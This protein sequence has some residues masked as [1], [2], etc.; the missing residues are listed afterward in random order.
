[1]KQCM[2][3]IRNFFRNASKKKLI[4]IFG[5][6]LSS[7]LIIAGATYA[8]VSFTITGTKDNLIKAGC[9]K[10]DL[11]EANNINLTNAV[12]VLDEQS[13]NLEPYKYTITNTCTTD[14]YYEANLTVLNTSNIENVSKMK[15]SLRGDSYL[16]PTIISALG[17]GNLPETQ[18]DVSLVYLLDSGYLKVGETKTFELRMWI[19]SETTDITGALDARIVM[20]A[21][22]KEGPRYKSNTSGYTV[23]KNTALASETGLN[24]SYSY[25]APYVDANNKYTQTSGLFKLKDKNNNLEYYFRGKVENNYLTFAGKTW[26]IIK[27]N[28]DGSLKLILDDVLST[29]AYSSASTTDSLNYSSSLISTSLQSW[30]NDNLK[31]NENYIVNYNYCNDLS[32]ANNYYGAYTRNVTSNSPSYFC[33]SDLINLNIGL[34]TADEIAYAGGLYN[35]NNTEYY[36]YKNSSWW[37]MS[38]A[39]YNSGAYMFNVDANG[40]LKTTLTTASN[41]YIRPVINLT[42]DAML[43]GNGT[44]NSKYNVI[45]F[46]TDDEVYVDTIPPVISFARSNASN[47]ILVGATDGARGSGI[48][49]YYISADSTTPTNSSEGWMNIK[50]E[51]FV[52]DNAYDPGTYYVWVK[53]ISGNISDYKKVI[54]SEKMNNPDLAS[55]MIPVY[56][57]ETSKVWRK[58]DSSNISEK[59]KWFDYS[60]KMWANAVTVRDFGFEDLSNNDTGATII[61]A[62]LSSEGLSFDGVDGAIRVDDGFGVTLPATYSATFKVDDFGSSYVVFIDNDTKIALYV[63]TEGNF[64]ATVGSSYSRF[65]AGLSANKFYN[66]TVV[67]NSLSDITVYVDGVS[68]SKSTT[69]SS[70]STTDERSY[71]GRRNYDTDSVLDGIIKN[72]MVW[73]EVLSQEQIESLANNNEYQNVPKNNLTTYFDFTKPITRAE[74]VNFGAGDIIPMNLINTMWVWIPRFNA[75]DNGTYNGGTQ[76][77][78]GAFNIEFVKN[79]EPAH[80]AFT[81][82]GK[83][84]NGFWFAKFEAG[85]DRLCASSGSSSSGSGCNLTTVSPLIKPNVNTWRGASVYAFYIAGRNMESESNDYGFDSNE[86]DTHMIKNNEWGAVAYLS[87]SIYGRCET[88]TSCSRITKNNSSLSIPGIGGDVVDETESDTNYKLAA[89]KYNGEFG[90][91]ASTTGNIY[92]IYDM[93]GGVWEYVMGNY[94]KTLG[95]SGFSSLPNAKY[96]NL[97][98]TEAAYTSA[99][100]QHAIFETGGWFESTA[101]LPSSSYPFSTRGAVYNTSAYNAHIFRADNNYGGPSTTITSRYTAIV[102]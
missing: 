53:D 62:T 52:T 88:M 92:G 34:I 23:L 41:I 71:I 18:T 27:I 61:D 10:I 49:G 96:Y 22:S 8:Y 14:A 94:N 57:D 1:M 48:G 47:Q 75:T 82:D 84:R 39:Y 83:E 99:G 4:A 85:K 2:I 3:K 102:N 15:V 42:K 38:P 77:S 93:V 43:S 46:F 30:Y 56:Y 50:T 79:T 66:V 44:L 9:L 97:Y 95:S 70:V 72:I 63:S 100:L 7:I 37:T 11:T 45:G 35:T 55:N 6:V 81:F 31:T 16:A 68:V 78:P 5:I 40:A 58:A 101:Y 89:N 90:M 80:D 67:A 33:A 91:L 13:L 32:N 74:A 29:S 87:Q 60:S 12:S 59:H 86:V 54:V 64:Y 69:T 28:E 25:I 24:P 26:R 73:D 65:D 20:S 21:I 51:N 76:T 36:L 19:A 17:S 98:T